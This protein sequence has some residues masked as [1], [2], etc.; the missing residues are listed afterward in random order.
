[1]P[2]SPRELTSAVCSC[3]RTAREPARPESRRSPG[4]AQAAPPPPAAQAAARPLRAREGARVPLHSPAR[5]ERPRGGCPAA[6]ESRSRNRTPR[7]AVLPPRAA[8]GRPGRERYLHRQHCLP[9]SPAAQSRWRPTSPKRSAPP[10][11]PTGIQGGP[12]AAA[13]PHEANGRAPAG[14]E[15]VA[16]QPPRG[17]SLRRRSLRGL[18][19][20]GRA[21][22]GRPRAL[23][24]L[25]HVT[26][27]AQLGR[28]K[29]GGGGGHGSWRDG[30]SPLP[31]SRS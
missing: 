12:G 31:G 9:S 2:A 17:R 14:S 21:A 15:R 6:P 25:R 11:G 23:P 24:A 19:G 20:P 26:A 8:R 13:A 18:I 27:G 28:V 10:P 30:D 22:P 4:P 1:M 7:E 3:G 16:R 29:R 5:R